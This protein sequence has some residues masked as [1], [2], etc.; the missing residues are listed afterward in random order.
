MWKAEYRLNRLY[1][2]VSKDVD[3]EID[4]M[5]RLMKEVCERKIPLDLFLITIASKRP[6]DMRIRQGALKK[7]I[8]EHLKRV[9]DE[10]E[11]DD[12]VAR[13][14]QVPEAL[15][16]Q[17]SRVRENLLFISTTIG[18]PNIRYLEIILEATIQLMQECHVLADTTA[19]DQFRLAVAAQGSSESRRDR[20][21]LTLSAFNEQFFSLLKLWTDAVLWAP[22]G[23]SQRLLSQQQTR[24]RDSLPRNTDTSA[25][26]TRHE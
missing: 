9:I 24:F 21:E 7:L 2:S 23:A 15:W 8:H 12:N 18:I 3:G 11:F 26:Q 19:L 14:H 16:K 20:T 13:D 22:Q 5:F 6:R 25:H 1:R 10:F 17:L 4:E